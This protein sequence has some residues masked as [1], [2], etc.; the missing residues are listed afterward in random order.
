MQ[1]TLR[2][3]LPPRTA[4]PDAACFCRACGSGKEKA[5]VVAGASS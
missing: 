1:A 4:D 5:P 2:A 3:D